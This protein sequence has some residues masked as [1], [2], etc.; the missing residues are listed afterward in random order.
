MK[1]NSVVINETSTFNTV[2][3]SFLSVD[4]SH[5]AVEP[6]VTIVR[7]SPA[8]VLQFTLG[9]LKSNEFGVSHDVCVSL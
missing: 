9:E 6:E 7:N 5:P 8:K 4:S 3:L 1:S 2:V